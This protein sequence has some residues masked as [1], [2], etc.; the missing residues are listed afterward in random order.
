MRSVGDAC[1]RRVVVADA[2][3]HFQ[4]MPGWVTPWL[5]WVDHDYYRTDSRSDGIHPGTAPNPAGQSGRFHVA[6]V[7]VEGIVRVRLLAVPGLG[8]AGA[9]GLSAAILGLT[10]RLGCRSLGRRSS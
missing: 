5:G 1:L 7:L 8:L 3:A 9:A 6:V 4:A 10:L 2:N